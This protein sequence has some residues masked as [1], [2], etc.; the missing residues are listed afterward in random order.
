MSRMGAPGS[1]S[2]AETPWPW[3]P[4]KAIT[5]FDA[6]NQIDVYLDPTVAQHFSREMVLLFFYHETAFSNIRQRT[7]TGMGAGVGF[8]QLEILKSDKPAFLREVYGMTPD[9][10]LF[11][12]ITGDEVFAIKLHCDYLK[13][14]FGRGANTKGALVDGQI[15]GNTQ[16]AWMKDFFIRSEL[17]LKSAIYGSDRQAIIDALNSSRWYVDAENKMDKTADGRWF[18]PIAYP[19]FQKYWDFTLPESE[20]MLGIRK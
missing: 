2:R 3:D 18:N 9:D 14:L 8:G 15:G 11:T 4:A 10:S 17:Q 13:H 20:L 19:R 1:W 6:T 12:K 16:N 5:F 7:K